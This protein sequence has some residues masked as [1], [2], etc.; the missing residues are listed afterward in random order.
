MRHRRPQG[1]TTRSTVSV[2]IPCYN[3]GRFLPGAVA[4]ALDQAGLDVNVIVVDDC[5]GVGA[6]AQ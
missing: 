5:S 6:G 4:S 3:Y 1:L 2:V